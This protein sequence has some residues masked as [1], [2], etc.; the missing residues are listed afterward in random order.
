MEKFTVEEF[1]KEIVYVSATSDPTIFSK[2]KEDAPDMYFKGNS[3]KSLTSMERLI[4]K[5]KR[6]GNR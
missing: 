4:E 2:G 3:E 1:D 6:G 5:H